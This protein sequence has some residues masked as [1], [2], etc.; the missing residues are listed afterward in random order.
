MGRITDA[1][2]EKFC[3]LMADPNTKSAKEAY[4]SINNAVTDESASNLG[5]Q[6]LLKSGIKERIRQLLE[7]N[8]STSTPFL[9]KKLGQLSTSEKEDISLRA[10][11]LGFRLYGAL[12]KDGEQI[13]EPSDIEINI[14]NTP[15]AK[16]TIDITNKDLRK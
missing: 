5:N 1:K 7:Q 3:R 11:E 10:V 4:K 8:T 16:P 6:L 15:Q 9:V 14:I 12:E 2:K 13:A